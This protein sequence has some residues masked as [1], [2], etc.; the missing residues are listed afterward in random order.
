MIWKSV[1]I[2]NFKGCKSLTVDFTDKTLICGQNASG[3][4]TVLDAVTWLLFG[5][6]SQDREKFEIRPLDSDGNK[7]H[8][9]EIS[10]VGVCEVDGKEYTFSRK[11]K[12]NWV[13]KRGSENP[14][15][16]GNTNEMEINGFPKSDKEYKDEISNI[17][18]EGL[19][20]ALSNPMYFPSLP[21]KDQ[22]QMLMGFVSDISDVDLAK[23]IGGFDDI[24]SDLE[25]ANNTDEIAKKYTKAKKELSE[26]AK[27]I[28]VRID[29]I[30]KSRVYIDKDALE[31][32]KK[33]IEN[34][35]DSLDKQIAKGKVDILDLETELNKVNLD[36]SRC[37]ATADE[38]LR[39]KRAS[40]KDSLSDAER[41]LKNKKFEKSTYS[42]R[43]INAKNDIHNREEKL[44]RMK[45]DYLEVKSHKM[46]ANATKCPA[47]G[48]EFDKDR[49]DEITKHFTEERTNKLIQI[50]KI[51]SETA[52]SID[53]LNRDIDAWNEKIS[54]IEKE[55]DTIEQLVEGIKKE[56]DNIP[57]APDYEDSD[58]Y[59]ELISQKDKIEVEMAERLA[60]TDDISELEIKR[61]ELKEQLSNIDEEL[62]KESMNQDIDNRVENLESEMRTVQQKI[63]DAERMEYQLN[64]FIK[65]K[66]ESVS[67]TIND[68]FEICNFKLFETQI[69]GGIKECCE[70]T[71][72]GVPYSSL[73]S[74]HKIIGGVDIVKSLQRL[75]GAKLP[76]WIDNAETVN[77]YNMPDIDCQMVL[78]K[79]T[80]DKELSIR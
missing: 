50:D 30:E 73:N 78:L 36:I 11:Q 76:I 34:Q 16:Q 79:V 19:F 1:K 24:L 7:I 4:T 45:A 69:N 31:N 17:V 10:V 72:N 22:R 54:I 35:I 60:N 57:D 27:E 53:N 48:R 51:A 41:E 65:A 32:K 39:E 74:G 6:D 42:D 49:I 37:T 28:P 21:W 58:K 33:G 25:Y 47:C 38:V 61:K 43:I 40:L 62:A 70:M 12:E 23:E 46:S 20:K 59:K 67:K 5:K 63:A 14:V 66:M 80:D 77:E 18:D 56:I 68:Q 64:N 29:E 15:L 55:I 26:K 3:K 44:E 52:E 9:V 13:K 71:V 75:L 2:E 8:N